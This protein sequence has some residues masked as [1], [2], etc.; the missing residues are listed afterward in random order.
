MGIKLIAADMDGTL[1]NTR[2]AVSMTNRI[3]INKAMAAGIIFVPATGRVLEALPEEIKRLEGVGYII[4]SNGAAVFKAGSAEAE[5]ELGLDNAK[6]VKVLDCLKD[7]DCIL[8]AYIKGR[9]YF[10]SEVLKKLDS[11]GMP[12]NFKFLYERV[13][14]PVENLLEFV[15]SSG[16]AVEKFNI[17]WLTPEQKVR[18]LEKLEAFEG[19]YIT[20]SLKSNVEVND[21]RANKGGALI[22]LCE[23]LGVD[24]SETMALGDSFNDRE[25]IEAAGMGVAMGNAEDEIK[26]L[27]QFV[28]KTNDEDGVAYAIE[29]LALGL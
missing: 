13:K 23:T 18:I 3:A 10:N 5:F 24:I 17:P 19:L 4:S 1:L 11:Y 25:M 20:S 9:G 16:L 26:R 2:G 15:H 14:K 7:E 29:K 8:E 22:R 28:T 12:E 21:I 27:A 6:A